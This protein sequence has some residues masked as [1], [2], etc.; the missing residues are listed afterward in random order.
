M[1]SLLF[2]NLI[3]KALQYSP[4]F[5][6]SIYNKESESSHLWGFFLQPG[7]FIESKIKYQ[8]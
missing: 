1:R 7:F 6:K 2:D 4:F 8:S 5:I 3:I